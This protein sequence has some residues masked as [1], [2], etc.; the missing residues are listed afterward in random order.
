MNR[1]ISL[2]LSGSVYS[3]KCLIRM[4]IIWKLVYRKNFARNPTRNLPRNPPPPLQDLATG[5]YEP[6]PDN[7]R[8]N[9]TVLLHLLQPA[10]CLS[11]DWHHFVTWPEA[12]FLTVS[13]WMHWTQ[14]GLFVL[15]SLPLQIFIRAVVFDF[16]VLPFDQVL[17]TTMHLSKVSSYVLSHMFFLWAL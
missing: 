9:T 3:Q 15:P 13:S 1:L 16:H 4:W 12:R 14:A 17:T 6:S 5:S 8:K 10:F 7:H 2:Q 11:P